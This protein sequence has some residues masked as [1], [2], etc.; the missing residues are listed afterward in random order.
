M[1]NELLW[2]VWLQWEH[3]N[4]GP[5]LS[6]SML[7]P[8]ARTLLSQ[9]PGFSCKRRADPLWQELVCLESG[10]WTHRSCA[11]VLKWEATSLM[12]VTGTI[13]SQSILQL[14]LSGRV[15]DVPGLE[16]PQRL[17]PFSWLTAEWE[18]LVSF[19]LGLG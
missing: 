8:S 4:C 5:W 19:T 13:H 6:R 11:S 15:A 14:L 9:Y 18:C 7:C 2:P 10:L 16:H 3:L 17:P 12:G 1:N